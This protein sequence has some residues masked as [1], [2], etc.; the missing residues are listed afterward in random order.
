MKARKQERSLALLAIIVAVWAI[1]AGVYA[2]QEP[3]PA[4]PESAG[5]A[6]VKAPE[7]LESLPASEFSRLVRELSEDGGFFRS[8]NF[9]SNE[10]AYLTVVDKLR[11]LGAS[12]GAILGSGADQNVTSILTG[13]QQTAVIR[14]Y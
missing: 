5:V 12:R 2:R 6:P 7:K 8:D 9:T 13:R 1:S 3:K 10:T 11:Q 4:N 14:N